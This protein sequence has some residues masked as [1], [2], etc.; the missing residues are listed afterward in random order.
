MS[1]KEGKYYFSIGKI[2]KLPLYLSPTKNAGR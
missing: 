1:T 2:I